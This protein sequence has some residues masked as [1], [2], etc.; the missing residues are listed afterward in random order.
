[1]QK[2]YTENFVQVY[3]TFGRATLL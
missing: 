1:M 3:S 2:N